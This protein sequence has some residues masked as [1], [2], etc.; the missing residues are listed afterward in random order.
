MYCTQQLLEYVVSEPS[1]GLFVKLLPF[2]LLRRLPQVLYI[3]QGALQPF[4]KLHF[5]Y[6]QQGGVPSFMCGGGQR[7]LTGIGFFLSPGGFQGRSSQAQDA[8][9]HWYSLS[10]LCVCFVQK[11][12]VS[13][14][15]CN[16]N[17]CSF[18]LSM[19]IFILH[20][21]FYK[22]S[23]GLWICWTFMSDLDF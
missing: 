18:S 8:W 10:L 1:T 22:P 13:R 20:N 23:V 12:G 4:L 16:M 5:I 19:C 2:Y 11:G 3:S 14:V 15:M 21:D 17:T 6:L 7:Q 9:D